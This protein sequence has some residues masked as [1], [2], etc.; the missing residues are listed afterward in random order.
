MG[1]SEEFSKR[2]LT[3]LPIKVKIV[4][5]YNCKGDKDILTEIK[6]K[7]N[8]CNCKYSLVLLHDKLI[9]NNINGNIINRGLKSYVSGYKKGLDIVCVIES[10]MIQ[11]DSW[12]GFD[13]VDSFKVWFKKLE[14]Q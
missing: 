8:T 13:S 1:Y 4:V 9:G 14:M 12:L 10:K 7:C 6:N 5:F 2:C 11:S 3:P